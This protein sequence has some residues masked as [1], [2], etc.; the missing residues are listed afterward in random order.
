[1]RSQLT[2]S[3]TELPG[4]N[5][6]R[7]ASPSSSYSSNAPPGRLPRQSCYCYQSCIDRAIKISACFIPQVTQWKADFRFSA[8]IKMKIKILIFQLS[9]SCIFRV[10]LSKQTEII[11]K[12][13]HKW[14]SSRRWRHQ[15]R[16]RQANGHELWRLSSSGPVNAWSR[17]LCPAD[18]GS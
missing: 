11:S 6:C 10:E 3:S 17:T 14:K 12:N 13:T 5:N 16:T 7:N 1:M 9:K 8:K 2:V 18:G 4:Y 15:H